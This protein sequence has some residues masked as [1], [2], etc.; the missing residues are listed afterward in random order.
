MVYSRLHRLQQMVDI[1]VAETIQQRG[2]GP[3]RV[4]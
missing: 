4:P 3:G 1:P 2:I